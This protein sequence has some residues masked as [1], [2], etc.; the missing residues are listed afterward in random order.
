MTFLFQL[1]HH[2]F[3]FAFG[4]P[5]SVPS[6]AKRI[7]DAGEVHKQVFCPVFRLIDHF[8]LPPRRFEQRFDRTEAEAC[9]SV[10]VLSDYSPG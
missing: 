8:D 7:H 4:A 2:F 1:L 6:G 3:C 10:L 5:L 9:P